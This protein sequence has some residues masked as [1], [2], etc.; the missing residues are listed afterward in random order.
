MIKPEEVKHIEWIYYR[1]VFKHQ[2]NPN[3]DYMIKFREILE[4]LSS[5]QVERG[6]GDDYPI[7]DLKK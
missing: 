5:K 2:E 7:I 1:M 4:K 6:C 3:F